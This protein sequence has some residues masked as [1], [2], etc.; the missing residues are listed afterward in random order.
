M[1]RFIL[2]LYL[3]TILFG[4]AQS[5]EK[6]SAVEVNFK[7]VFGGI[8]INKDS[9]YNLQGAKIKFNVLKMFVCDVALARNIGTESKPAGKGNNIFLLD[10]FA[11]SSSAVT[12]MSFEI[13]PGQYSDLRFSLGVGRELNH[14]DPTI[15]P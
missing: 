4:R 5:P 1:R 15:A 14:S 6:L 9:V 12:Q 2:S 7:A 11:T 3:L 10:F 8:A 13:V